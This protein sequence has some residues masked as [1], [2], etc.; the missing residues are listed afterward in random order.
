MVGAGIQEPPGGATVN[1]SDSC[2]WPGQA[3]RMK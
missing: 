3:R 2:A 1:L